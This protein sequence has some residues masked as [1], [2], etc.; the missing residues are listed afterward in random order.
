MKKF[1]NFSI[2]NKIVTI[3]L[4]ISTSIVM[5]ISF[6]YT[7]RDIKLIRG[8]IA[9]KMTTIAE[10]TGRNSAAA[11]MFN[12]SEAAQETLSSLS[13]EKNI[14]VAYI[15]DENGKI[16][17]RYDGSK[18][19]ETF[20]HI[21]HDGKETEW[22][23]HEGLP[24]DWAY[25]AKFW[26]DHFD[27]FQ[28]IVVDG[29]VI[30]AIFIEYNLNDL[31]RQRLQ[32]LVVAIALLVGA[33]LLAYLL[34]KRAQQLITKPIMVLTET[35][36]KISDD[37][38]YS[39]RADK[40]SND[41][42]GVL[43]D[44]FNDMLNQIESRDEELATHRDQLEDAVIARTAELQ[45]VTERACTMAQQA[46]AANIAKSAFL[47]NMSHELRTPLNAIIGFSEV[48]IDKHFGDVN[49]AQEDYLNDILTSGRHLLSLVQDILDISKVE[50]GMMTLDV[51]EVNM[52]DLLQGSLVMVKEKAMKHG[53]KLTVETEGIPDL[54]IADE[55]KIKQV[56]FN[57][58]SNAAKFTP[59]N[60]SIDI[61]AEVIGREWLQD[62]IPDIFRAEI[63]QLMEDKA[64]SYFKVSIRD[65]G[66]G[67]QSESLK[68]ILEPFQQE[69]TSTSRRYGG[70][71]L[72]LSMS[73]KLIELHK[74]IIWI[75]SIADKGST[76]SFVV[77]IVKEHAVLTDTQ[78]VCY[79]GD[80][81]F[82]MHAETITVEEQVRENY[83]RSL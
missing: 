55:R 39:V 14:S 1:R 63:D 5:I 17:A 56:V 81:A 71:G 26:D 48:L 21:S 79:S 4:L 24:S 60:G 12:D 47:A 76:F 16:F 64:Q 25:K 50:A 54:I 35:M 42:I 51:S 82:P 33:S 15:Y 11:I 37:R 29:D 19:E 67:I 65:T 58:L 75:E 40:H 78:D 10:V 7:V 57:L 72:G 3:I 18:R 20:Q 43:I 68:R 70:T 13:A 73:K 22:A 30:G 83:K 61:R 52:K 6:L 38:I 59:D 28:S 9:E 27:V 46:E 80:A 36:N 62:N 53:I 77:P 2:K 23:S 32:L 49:E 44:G 8:M 74:G 31:R 45:E 41:E 66:I 34:S 69:D